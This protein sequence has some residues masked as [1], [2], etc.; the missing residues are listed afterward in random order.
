M[1]EGY[2]EDVYST[3][4]KAGKRTYFFDVKA[5]K[6]NDLFLTITESKRIGSEDQG[7]VRFEKHKIVL[8]K[9]DFEGFQ[10]CLEDTLEQI[11]QL[12][13]TGVYRTAESNR[14]PND[15]ATEST[16]DG[17]SFDDL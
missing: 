3:S 7:P 17:M 2:K 14:K 16:S 10:N 5:T 6:G 11:R 13:G 9:E 15:D 8:Y 12:Q 4:V 1:A